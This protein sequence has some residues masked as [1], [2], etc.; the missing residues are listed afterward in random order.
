M[1]AGSRLI[2][3][4]RPTK[5]VFLGLSLLRWFLG[6]CCLLLLSFMP[7]ETASGGST[8]VK[9]SDVSYVRTFEKLKALFIFL[10]IVLM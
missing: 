6:E 1:R 5:N 7:P 9:Q 10:L 3:V 2:I 8:F 4:T